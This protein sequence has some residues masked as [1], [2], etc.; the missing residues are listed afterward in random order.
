MK[1]LWL[2]FIGL[3]LIQKI[4]AQAVFCP[5]GAEWHYL[6]SPILAYSVQP[7][8]NER[9]KYTKD[10]IVGA[11]TVKVLRHKWYFNYCNFSSDAY[12]LIKQKGDTVFMRSPATGNLWQILYNY[13]AT[14]GQSWTTTI[15][16][17]YSFSTTLTYTVF[18]DSVTTTSSNN[19]VLK[20]LNVRYRKPGSPFAESSVITERIGCTRFM[21]NYTNPNSFTD[22]VG[23]LGCICY[24]DSAFGLKQYVSYP[25]DATPPVGIYE[26]SPEKLTIQISPNPTN[27]F[28]TIGNSENL[29]NESALSIYDSNGCELKRV[30]LKSA[31]DCRIFIGDLSEGLY[32]LKL[33]T[34][35][36]LH[37]GKLLKQN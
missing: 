26:F 13:A 6:F 34:R 19:Y 27:E 7:Y 29:G 33:K 3:F 25:C 18:V 14:A 30:I 17:L 1:N 2:I 10:S 5:K 9:I 12:T 28:V 31:E 20:K 16:S 15:C 22:A 8:Y 37:S 21:Y 24:Q 23:A 35:D 11:D 4:Q 32:F 36:K